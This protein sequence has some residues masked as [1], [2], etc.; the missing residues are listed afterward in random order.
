MNEELRHLLE[1]ALKEVAGED[2]LRRSRSG[3]V[4]RRESLRAHA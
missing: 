2:S 1:E 3:R 4:V